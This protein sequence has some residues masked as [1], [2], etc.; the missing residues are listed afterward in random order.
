VANLGKVMIAAEGVSRFE[1]T[2]SR[3]LRP[4]SLFDP[5]RCA[6]RPFPFHPT[7]ARLPD[8]C[9]RAASP[10]RAGRRKWGEDENCLGAEAEVQ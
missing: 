2:S 1:G 4:P 5:L 9:R 6:K 10:V 8:A 7:R 3:S